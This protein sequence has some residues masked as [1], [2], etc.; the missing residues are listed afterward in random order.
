[1]KVGQV[2]VFVAL[3]AATAF[4][5]GHEAVATSVTAVAG[6]VAG[7]TSEPA[8]LLLSGSVLL[9]LAGAVKRFTV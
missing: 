5:Y 4:A 3:A 2:L 1:M 7:S 6:Q 8:A 9:G